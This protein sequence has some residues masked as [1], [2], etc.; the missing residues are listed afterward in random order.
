MFTPNPD[1]PICS[2]Q[3]KPSAQYHYR[4]LLVGPP[5]SFL[6]PVL[7]LVLV[8]VLCCSTPASAPP[9]VA[10]SSANAACSRMA[11][12]TPPFLDC[13]LLSSLLPR[14]PASRFSYLYRAPPPPPPP[15]VG[16]SPPRLRP[17]PS[18]GS[19]HHHP[20][21][22]PPPPLHHTP[23]V[24]TPV[25]LPRLTLLSLPPIYLS[26]PYLPPTYL[27]LA[28]LS[29]SFPYCFFCFFRPWTLAFRGLCA[30][31]VAMRP[32]W[33]LALASWT[34]NAFPSRSSD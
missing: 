5:A 28:A 22:P 16:P 3:P 11:S 27:S 2:R 9:L 10:R 34:L 12:S 14:R 17:D 15:P 23:L 31:C 19:H 30:L 18:L 6:F 7:V 1:Y 21:P 25:A 4:C 32:D 29:D 26:N 24:T 13:C 8:R 20:H 33:T